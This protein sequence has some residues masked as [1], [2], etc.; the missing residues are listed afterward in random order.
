M[1]QATAGS[2]GPRLADVSTQCDVLVR[3]GGVA[4]AAAALLCARR[5]LAVTLVEP[6]RSAF[7]GPFETMVASAERMLQRIGIADVVVAAARRD[8]MRHGAAWGAPEFVWRDGEPPGLL[9]ARGAFDAALRAAAVAAG[10]RVLRREPA[11]VPASALQFDA[12]GRAAHSGAAPVERGPSLLAVTVVGA[13]HAGDAGTATVEATADGW[14]WTHAPDRAHAGAAVFVDGAHARRAGLS[15]LVARQLAA[16][17][18][19]A[20][21]LHG[22]RI[23]HATD[24]TARLAAPVAGVL[25][26]GDAA[27]TIDP[28][29]SQGVEKALAA[30]DHAAA[31][32]AAAVAQPAWR[33]RLYAAHARW[34]AGL[35]RAHGATAQAWYEREGRFAEQPFWVGRRRDLPTPALPAVDAPL[36]VAPAVRAIT[37][38]VRAGADFVAQPGFVHDGTGEERSHVGFLP[39][40]ALLSL[41]ASPAPLAAAV[42]RGGADARLF[43]LPPRAVHAACLDLLRSGWLIPAVN[44]AGNR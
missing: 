30:A 37:A 5:G 25:R 20:R 17:T 29:A 8:P 19:P 44:A 7:S 31:V 43:V 9:L 27:G 40:A 28:L 36:T 41:F 4:G 39:L 38:L 42:A 35:W 2:S 26:L 18:G 3:G 33:E 1:G 10:V 16:A 6:G 14:I 12:R 32:A 34:E 23:Q 21:R 11:D 24:A 22:A 15:H 13:P